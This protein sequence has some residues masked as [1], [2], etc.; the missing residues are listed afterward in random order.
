M[1]RKMCRMSQMPPHHQPKGKQELKQRVPL[2]QW[3][4]KRTLKAKVS[5]WSVLALILLLLGISLLQQPPLKHRVAGVHIVVSP[6][7]ITRSGSQ[8]MLSGHP[9]RFAAANIH[10]LALDDTMTY[11]SQFRVND[12]F[13]TAKE[14][15]LTVVRSHNIGISTG[16]SNCLEPSLGVFNQVAFAHD[17]YVI[18]AAADHGMRLILPLTDNW[19]Y[20]TGGKHTFTDWRGIADEN[21]FYRN[22]QVISDFE[23]YVSTLLNHVNSYTGVA[24]KNDPTIMAWETGN[25]LSPPTKWTQT[26]STYIKSIDAK[27]LV[28]DGRNGVDPHAAS[29]ANV[30]IVSYHYYPMDVGK[31]ASDAAAAQNAGK[32]FFAGEY[33]WNDASVSTLSSFLS[34]IESNPVIAGDAF[35]ELWSHDDLYG[36][37]NS[38]I[39]FTVHYPGD[40][41]ALRSSVQQLR[42]HAYKLSGTA[43]PADSVPGVPLIDAITKNGA[44]NVLEWRGTAVAASYSIERSTAGAN[45]P[46][47]VICDKCATDTSTPWLDTTTPAGILWYRVT[48]YNLSGIAGSPSSP[49]QEG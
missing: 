20:A 9:F 40:S 11:P 38:E 44:N 48:A 17:D 36:Y 31:L 5:L 1:I 39:R 46:W 45:G 2:L 42:T 6:P 35:W 37:P 27:H 49:Y 28:V 22:A 18:K 3:Y 12:A 23:T 15:G 19:R 34:T 30:D 10:W 13:D 43:I 41:L 25:E 4:R 21:Q 32:A 26:I 14:M 7:F 24:Y 8:L 29:L 33:D 47:A 16:C